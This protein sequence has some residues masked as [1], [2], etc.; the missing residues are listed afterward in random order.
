MKKVQLIITFVTLISL[1]GGNMLP[2]SD[3]WLT[4]LQ[5][6]DNSYI[7]NNVD[8]GSG[9]EGAR[10]V[11]NA[12]SKLPINSFLLAVDCD[13]NKGFF[14][15]KDP[16][17]K[18]QFSEMLFNNFS[19]RKG[20]IFIEYISSQDFCFSREQILLLRWDGEP[21]NYY[22]NGIGY[23]SGSKGFDDVLTQINESQGEKV[24]FM[25]GALNIEK[26]TFDLYPLY[27]GE[28]RKL[29][30]V[31]KEKK[32]KHIGKF[33]NIDC[34]LEPVINITTQ[35]K[36]KLPPLSKEIEDI[37]ITGKYETLSSII[38]QFNNSLLQFHSDYTVLFTCPDIKI[39]IYC[40]QVSIA[41]MIQ[42]LCTK[43]NLKINVVK[44]TIII[45]KDD[46]RS[47]IQ[48]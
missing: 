34:Y 3:E 22:L 12:L 41:W 17:L 9:D 30:T 16:A 47:M 35:E 19:N 6:K 29:A 5:W 10:K 43:H 25:V 38:A 23:G 48:P 8:C 26:S 7:L 32:I 37:K 46:S 20:G 28:L 33:T 13:A 36:Y 1:L 2:A 44:N 14:N 27:R 39:G 15:T 11:V 31:L 45:Q 18:K 21:L 4:I 24:F 42:Y 40:D